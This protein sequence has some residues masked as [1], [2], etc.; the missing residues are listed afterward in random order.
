MTEVKSH[1]GLIIRSYRES[2]R[3]T[4]RELA[5]G[6]NVSVTSL[7]DIEEG[8]QKIT[9]EVLMIFADYFKVSLDTIFNQLFNRQENESTIRESFKHILDHYEIAKSEE[10]T[11]HK[12]GNFVRSYVK[13]VI[14]KEVELDIEHFEVTGSVGK[15]RWAEIPWIAIFIKDITKTATK[16]Y[17]IVYLFKA[18]MSGMYISLNQGWTY[19]QEKYGT[20]LGQEKIRLTA[21]II[22]RKINSI[23]NHMNL[24][25]IELGG[26]GPLSSGYEYGHVC[27]RFYSANNLP[28][29]DKLVD[30]LKALV[31]S[32]KEIQSMMGKRSV[33][34]FNDYLLLSDDSHYLEGEPEQEE[35]FQE[36]IQLVSTEEED[37]EVRNYG[38]GQQEEASPRLSPVFDIVGR[39]RWPRDAKVAARALR[40]SGYICAYNETHNSF[41]SKVTGKRY[42]EI[43]HLVPM[44]YQGEFNVSL[45]KTKQLL[46]LCPTCHRQ[47]HLGTDKDKK[48]MIEA[49]FYSHYDK[50]QEVG[51]SI[52]VKKLL[53]MYGIEEQE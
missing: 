35:D 14:I 12:I 11:K 4:Q 15:G 28:S 39:K 6:L 16:G 40:S 48:K 22:K 38:E 53:G 26:T 27:G 3:L 47:I 2:E 30:D 29:P 32:Y 43:H 9:N 50:L 13:N 41:I 36:N 24:K 52:E 7:S 21:D 37:I 45:D 10:F 34:E 42:L 1:L 18:D 23:P 31:T 25:E 19:F 20:K 46:A 17:Y 44:K 5:K 33:D 49:L 8:N 51:I